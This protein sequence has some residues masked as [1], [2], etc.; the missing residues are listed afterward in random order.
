M[1]RILLAMISVLALASC[2]LAQ[3][4]HFNLD[5]SGD[6]ELTFDMTELA[7][8]GG[9]TLED[10]FADM[11]LDSLAD[12][13]RSVDGISNVAVEKDTNVL[14]ISYSFRDLAA[15]NRSLKQQDT[16]ELGMSGSPDKFSYADGV[17]SYRIGNLNNSSESDSLAEMMDF[18]H[19][20]IEMRFAKKIKEANNGEVSEDERSVKMEGTFGEV[21][22]KERSLDLDVRFKTFADEK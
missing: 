8:F 20:D 7:E 9:D 4:Y 18:I 17:F 10:F 5:F 11:N 22:K 16:P 1:K 6:Y 13:Y 15:L 3:Q 14:Y 19:Y 21:L 12:V 2:K